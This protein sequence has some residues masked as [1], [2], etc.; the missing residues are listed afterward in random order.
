[1]GLSPRVRG[2]QPPSR[3]IEYVERSIPARAGEPRAQAVERGLHRVYP[4][5]VRGN[6]QNIAAA[7]DRM[8]SI[9]ARA[10]EP[11]GRTSVR[12][13]H[14]VYPRACG[15]TGAAHHPGAADGGLSPRVRGNPHVML[16]GDAEVGSIPARAGEPESTQAQVQ[17][18]G[19]YPRAC[20]GTG[21]GGFLAQQSYGL[22]PRVRGNPE[23]DAAVR[24]LGGSIPA[25]AG[26]PSTATTAGNMTRVYPRACGGTR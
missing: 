9:P 2:N 16:V 6:L 18:G 24:V 15:G 21:C 17:L 22:S 5:R 14:A 7:R 3:A 26:E 1:M 8:R 19:V 4:P 20:G 10:G 23:R 12:T 11:L 25:R 13:I